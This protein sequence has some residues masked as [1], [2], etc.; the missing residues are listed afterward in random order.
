MTDPK[1]VESD[2]A[3]RMPFPQGSVTERW[4][5][6]TL[7]SI[8]I[9]IALLVQEL[10]RGW[11]GEKS[12]LLLYPTLF[13][14]ALYG[15]LIPGIAATSVAT[16]GSWYLFV[17][18]EYSFT[19]RSAADA[20][21]LSVFCLTGILS[22]WIADRMRS[23]RIKALKVRELAET[24]RVQL[25]AAEAKFRGLFESVPDGIIVVDSNGVIAIV[26]AQAE[27]LFG[28]TR[29][30]ML[31]QTIE[32][33]VPDEMK[34]AHVVLR[35]DYVAHPV[36]RPMGQGRILPGRRKDGRHVSIEIALSPVKI[37][38]ASFFVSVVRDATLRG[39]I[40]ADI[41]RAKSEAEDASLAKS[42][43]LANM[44]HEI[45]TPLGAV[46]G[47]SELVA[48]PQI[49]VSEKAAY[50]AAIKRN[51]ELLSTIINDI[52]DLSKVEAG[53]MVV[54][55]REA[56]LTEILSDTKMLLDLY[57]REKGIALTIEVDR[58]V[59][60]IIKTDP[61]RL[62]QILINIIGNA[63][64]FTSR[65]SVGLSIELVSAQ[66]GQAK[67]VLSVADT[68]PGIEQDHVKKLFAPFSQADAST[69]RKY[70]GTGLG[71]VLSKRLAGLLGGDVVLT[72]TEAGRGSTFTITID[73]GPMRGALYG[74]LRQESVRKHEEPKHRI[75]GLRILLVDDAVDNQVLI[76][77]ILR[78]S[79][80]QVDVVSNGREAVLKAATA[81]HD[82]I[83]MDLQMPVMDGYEATTELRRQGYSGKI[84]A[85]T[86]HALSDEKERCL[87]SGFDGHLSKPINRDVLIQEL[88]VSSKKSAE[89]AAVEPTA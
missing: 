86:A 57:A 24:S 79:G 80:A 74:E 88:S 10:A 5:N 35:K 62:R 44:S 14:G 66:N 55:I 75:D 59:P 64:K 20:F 22:S 23:T 89:T 42:A 67:L 28:Y 34:H 83:L 4:L 70:G 48:D 26:N 45:R 30:Q 41:Q 77:R 12:F 29:D 3:T 87:K 21:A 7:P 49:G 15:G 81:G 2:R 68:G 58:N 37:D 46:I 63:I 85:L 72:S 73:P 33:L 8:M 19:F 25:Q 38:G 27:K 47:F 31:G 53:K 16:F 39:Q 11:I 51:G 61:L 84:I 69:R 36:P 13:L 82:V 50:V 17:P 32:L 65:G 60:A 76:E 71:L 54:D 78:L 18:Y 40:E 6:R 43:F 9:L 1:K 56:A 52:L